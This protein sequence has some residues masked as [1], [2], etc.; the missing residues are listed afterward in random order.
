M[1]V[2]HV[3]FT[4]FSLHHLLHAYLT[5]LFFSPHITVTSHGH[6]PTAT[7]MAASFLLRGFFQQAIDFAAIRPVL[8]HTEILKCMELRFYLTLVGLN[9]NNL[10]P[11]LADLV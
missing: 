10:M 1:T 4:L 6:P 2:P 5:I 11:V 9:F 7:I 8:Q 3:W